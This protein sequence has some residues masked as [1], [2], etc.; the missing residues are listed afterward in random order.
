ML[1]V[2]GSAKLLSDL[3]ERIGLAGIAGEIL[4]GV[5]IGPSVLH[6]VA[7]NETMK[8]LSDLGVLFLLFTIGLDVK[9]AELLRV[10]L[11]ST[12]VAALGELVPFIAVWGIVLA[13]GGTANA[14]LF[15]GA[16][17][18]ATSVGISASVLKA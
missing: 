18:V 3:F 10:S 17:L 8:A 11:L 12:L 16:S 1:I 5:L 13:W 14:A 2:F 7:P 6:L 15:M 4:A 9:L